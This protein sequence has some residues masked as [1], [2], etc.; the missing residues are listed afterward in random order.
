MVVEVAEEKVR[1]TLTVP[2]PVYE[3]ARS[4][5]EKKV[6]PADTITA[7]FLAAIV[8]YLKFLNRKQIDAKFALMAEDADY[9]K[10]AKLISEEFAASDWEAFEMV[11]KDR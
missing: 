11:E 10:Q 2:K 3:E 9:Q 6:T 7:F 5:V 8:Q 1:T 4:F